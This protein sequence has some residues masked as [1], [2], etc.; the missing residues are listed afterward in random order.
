MQKSVLD[1]LAT[2][3]YTPFLYKGFPMLLDHMINIK[4]SS[5]HPSIHPLLVTRERDLESTD[6][7]MP[8]GSGFFRCRRRAGCL[9][10]VR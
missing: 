7:N 2:H 5:S 10:P 4:L 8:V 6:A 1:A 9:R 3:R